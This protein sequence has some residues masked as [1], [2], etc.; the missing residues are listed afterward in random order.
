M[1]T[2][3]AHIHLQ[4]DVKP[5]VRHNPIPIPYHWK[6]EVKASLDEDVCRG[7]IAPVPIGTPVEWCTTMVITEKKNGKLRRTIDLQQLNN[8]CLRETHHCPS[9]F[10][11]ACQ[12]PPNT[13]KTILDA[14][15]GY[16]AIALDE[17]SQPL[18]AFITEWGRYMYLCMPQGFVAS[19]DA[20][21]YQTVQRSHKGHTT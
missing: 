12:V 21:L 16:H 18:T 14:V 10:Q 3:P 8:H 2:P 13:K 1:K 20:C 7:I 9:P 17:Q 11:L 19:G 6:K 5:Y 15:D 4:P